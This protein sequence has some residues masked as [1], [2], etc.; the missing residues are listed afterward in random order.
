MVEFICALDQCEVAFDH[1]DIYP[2]W[3]CE[4]MIIGQ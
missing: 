1:A 4:L 2:G 3:H